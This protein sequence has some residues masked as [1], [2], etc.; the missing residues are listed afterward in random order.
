MHL[1]YR[2]YQI[3]KP[4]RSLSHENFLNIVVCS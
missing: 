4:I 3:H 2:L 1:Q